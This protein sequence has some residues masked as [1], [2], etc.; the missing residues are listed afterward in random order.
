[1][2]PIQSR[3]QALLDA[4]MPRYM[5]KCRG[6]GLDTTITPFLF[7]ELTKCLAPQVRA[8]LFRG[9]S[10][11]ELQQVGEGEV[12]S[13][14]ATSLKGRFTFIPNGIYDY[15]P[16]PATQVLQSLPPFRFLYQLLS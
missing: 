3:T 7:N 15:E 10:T 14:V 1:M 13:A 4:G 6:F 16:V 11:Q 12:Q 5:D 8:D 2:N 9:S